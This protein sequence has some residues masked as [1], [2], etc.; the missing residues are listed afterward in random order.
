[1]VRVRETFL[2]SQPSRLIVSFLVAFND[3]FPA[4]HGVEE[5]E[6]AP[7]SGFDRFVLASPGGQFVAPVHSSRHMHSL[8][9]PCSAGVPPHP[10]SWTRCGMLCERREQ[11]R[12]GLCSTHDSV[13]FSTLTWQD[14]CALLFRVPQAQATWAGRC[15]LSYG[16]VLF[17]IRENYSSFQC[18]FLTVK[19]PTCEAVRIA[20]SPPGKRLLSSRVGG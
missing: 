14:S 18:C 8:A 13:S 1:V 10:H 2:H 20:V 19:G 6:E 16:R 12:I 15:E 9:A 17:R 5:A 7:R 3:H 11:T 4:G